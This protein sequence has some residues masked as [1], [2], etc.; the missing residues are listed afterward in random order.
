MAKK[1]KKILKPLKSKSNKSVK[2]KIRANLTLKNNKRIIK[3]TF[4]DKNEYITDL[5]FI[6]KFEEEEKERLKLKENEALIKTLNKKTYIMK[7]CYRPISNN[8]ELIG[9]YLQYE[10][11]N[12]DKINKNMLMNNK[13]S[14]FLLQDNNIIVPIL[15]EEILNIDNNKNNRMNNGLKEDEIKENGGEKICKKQRK[16]GKQFFYLHIC[17]KNLVKSLLINENS[18]INYILI[19]LSGNYSG[20]FEEK[21]K[22]N[23]TIFKVDS[24]HLFLSFS[25]I[26][27]NEELYNIEVFGKGKDEYGKYIIK[28]KLKLIHN[29]EQYKKE[30]ES[31]NIN[32]KN[33]H[34][35]KIIYFGNI[36][37]HKNYNI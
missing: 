17:K 35:N 9:S 2:S 6:D 8:V 32:I 4:K 22:N 10:E 19:F 14:Y 21:N 23:S 24:F 28:G 37:F 25:N 33:N 15:N 27:T 12:M 5:S 34:I 31:I 11:N 3:Q 7:I 13:C 36:S 18:I 26:K 30:N 16:K 20:Y 29:I 1:G